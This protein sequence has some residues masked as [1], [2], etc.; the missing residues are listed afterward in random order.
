MA[1]IISDDIL[2]KAQ[3]SGEDLLIDL[4]CYLYEKQRFSL[5]Q[6]RVLAGLDQIAFQKE[7]ATRGVDI[8]FSKDDL[9]Q[10]LKNLGID[11]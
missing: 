3:V 2:S 4:A 11:L 9:N 6:A 1:L 8:H 7:L 10:D 5:G